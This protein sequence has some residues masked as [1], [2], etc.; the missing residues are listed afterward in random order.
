ME[1]AMATQETSTMKPLLC[2]LEEETVEE[3]EEAEILEE[4][5]IPRED[6]VGSPHLD[7]F[8]INL[9]TIESCNTNLLGLKHAIRK[10]Y[11]RP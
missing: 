3:E 8:S 9:M 2:L 10:A 5:I 11:D 6:C 1:S 4:E 7:Q